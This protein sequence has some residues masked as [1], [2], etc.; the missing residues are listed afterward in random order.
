MVITCQENF[1]P[2]GVVETFYQWYLAYSRPDGEGNFADPLVYGAYREYPYLAPTLIADIDNQLT[3]QELGA[4]D[5]FLCAQ[6]RPAGVSVDIA[7]T[8]DTTA[9]GMVHEFFTGN[10]MRRD[11]LME[12]AGSE[13]NW[14]INKIA[15]EVTPEAVALVFFNEYLIYARYDVE[16]DI[17]R[18]PV[19][20]WGFRWQDYLTP[21]LL[22]SVMDTFTSEEI[23]PADPLSCAQDLPVSLSAEANAL[24]D[25]QV[26]IRLSGEYPSGPDTYTASPLVE[27]ELQLIDGQWQL[28]DIRC[29][30]A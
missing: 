3:N 18:T 8:T 26:V 6:D 1:T 19:L 27:A 23:F 9:T 14:Q 30:A 25:T 5:P 12:L 16:H 21:E 29:I 4:G 13:N 17:E 15:C 11:L 10:G 28:T 2:E 24:T 22:I 20:D 7:S